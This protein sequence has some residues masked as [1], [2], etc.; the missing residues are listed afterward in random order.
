MSAKIS[1]QEII[2]RISSEPYATWSEA[3]CIPV[4]VKEA[5]G[6]G[7]RKGKW[8]EDF[9][10][11]ICAISNYVSVCWFQGEWQPGY[12]I[13]G[14][15]D[16]GTVQGFSHQEGNELMQAAQSA[17][18][19]WL[20]PNDH[21]RLSVADIG[22]N[23]IVLVEIPPTIRMCSWHGKAYNL[24][25]D[26][27]RPIDVHSTLPFQFPYPTD[28]SADLCPPFVIN[29]LLVITYA[30]YTGYNIRQFDLN[31]YLTTTGLKDTITAC[32]LFGDI[33]TKIGFYNEK[34]VL[35]TTREEADLFS[36]LRET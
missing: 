3:R 24:L 6:A 16:K 18:R 19:N 33:K 32:V 31:K 34:D 5:Q 15:T 7:N 14:T 13:M 27:S 11:D 10:Q 4:E 1:T 17:L 25:G 29:D 26:G 22:K 28:T 20:S 12:F 2:R 36:L 9:G 30:K 35:V 8:N 21:I 23:F